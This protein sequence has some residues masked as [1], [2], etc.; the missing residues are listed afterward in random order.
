[1]KPSLTGHPCI[2]F[3][4]VRY[5]KWNPVQLDSHV[6]NS[7]L[8]VW[9]NAGLPC[10]EFLVSV[11]ENE[12]QYNWTPMYRNLDKL[13]PLFCLL[14]RI[15]KTRIIFLVVHFYK[16]N[17]VQLASLVLNS[18]FMNWN[19]CFLFIWENETQNNLTP[20]SRCVCPFRRIKPSPTLFWEYSGINTKLS[21]WSK[22]CLEGVSCRPT[23]LC[24]TSVSLPHHLDFLWCLTPKE[25]VEHHH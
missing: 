5:G 7:R 21:L 12:T 20:N 14:E 15:I 18:W 11:W 17:P 4:V 10:I 16:W 24:S 1:M 13:T 22:F 9:E 8:S 23:H 19:I 2:E 25:T 6:L 3:L